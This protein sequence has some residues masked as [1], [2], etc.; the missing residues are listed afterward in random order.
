[1][2]RKRLMLSRIVPSLFLLKLILPVKLVPKEY[3]QIPS[4]MRVYGLLTI[5][6]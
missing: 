4:L 2:R 1:M 5:F 6:S 3:L